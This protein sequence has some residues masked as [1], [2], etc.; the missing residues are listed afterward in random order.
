MAKKKEPR[1]ADLDPAELVCKYTVCVRK[2]WEVFIKTKGLIDAGRC[3]EYQ[4][5]LAVKRELFRRLGVELAPLR[6]KK[7]SPATEEYLSEEGG[8]LFSGG[9]GQGGGMFSRG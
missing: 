2:S 1:L 6:K 9:G 3:S 7:K 5:E 8:G 4:K